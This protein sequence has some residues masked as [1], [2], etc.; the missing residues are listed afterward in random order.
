MTAT[1]KLKDACSLEEQCLALNNCSITSQTP[2]A[3]Y[4]MLAFIYNYRKGF[5]GSSDGKESTCNAGDLD[6]M[7]GLGRSPGEG[8][9]NRLQHSYW[10]IPWSEEPGG[11]SQWGHKDLDTTESLCFYVGKANV[12]I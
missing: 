9:D 5:P 3:T 4:C 1:M 8:N 12:K 2:K 11:S 10:R 6:S 7:S